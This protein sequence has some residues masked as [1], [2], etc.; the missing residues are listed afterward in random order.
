[1]N[2]HIECLRLYIKYKITIVWK[3]IWWIFKFQRQLFVR[4]YKSC[5]ILR[6]EEIKLT[7]SRS[8]YIYTQRYRVFNRATFRHHF[9]QVI[10]LSKF[11]ANDEILPFSFV[12]FLKLSPSL[13]IAID[14]KANVRKLQETSIFEDRRENESFRS[15]REIAHSAFLLVENP[16]MYRVFHLGDGNHHPLGSRLAVISISSPPFLPPLFFFC[17]AFI[18]ATA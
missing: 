15:K 16:I 10:S 11:P 14:K 6:E 13:I 12:S 9:H 8:K 5:A 2:L 7:V 17:F 1:M 4:Y 3:I 18:T